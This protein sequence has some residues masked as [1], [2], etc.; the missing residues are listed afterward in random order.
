[1][2]AIAALNGGTVAPSSKAEASSGPSKSY[3]PFNRPAYE[4]IASQAGATAPVTP[5]TVVVSKDETG[6]ALP[7]GMMGLSFESDIMTD[8]RLDPGNS[9]LVA[10]LKN[11]TKPVIRFGGQAADRRFFWT[12]ASE[13]LP[14]W[15][16]VPAF[17][18]DT[19]Q[20]V[21]VTPA[22]LE[23]IN[24]TVVAAD[25]KVL[26]TADL[27][28]FDPD[29]AADFAK[30]ASA[31]FGERLLGI[32][33]GNE[34]NG[35]YVKGNPYLTLRPE[36]WSP[37]KFMDEFKAYESA[38]SKTA[39][40]VK[41]IGPETYSLNWLKP[42]A[43][44]QTPSL[45]ALSYHNYPL[46]TCLPN[47][48]F[49]PTIARVTSRA[50]MDKVK[51]VVANIAKVAKD[52]G[53]PVWLTESG[54]SSCPGSNET[55]RKHVAAMWIV[56]YALTVAQTGVTQLD[57][58]GALDTCKGG[59][60]ASPICDTGAYKRPTGVMTEQ[61]I[62]HGM[63]LVSALA[64]GMFHNVDQDGS[65]NVYS[66]AIGHKD[67]SMS[68][69]V[70]NQNDPKLSAQAPVAIQLPEAAATATMSQMTGPAFD[71]EAQTQIDSRED[72]GVPES[73]RAMIPG[74][75][76]GQQKVSLPLTSGTVT[77]LTFTF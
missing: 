74:F 44:Q 15:K 37:S 6:T 9:T 53:L 32:A 36:D 50:H 77:V 60:P 12:S 62:Y 13:G 18:G 46:S 61:A 7:D 57:V 63:M 25:A 48:E 73:Q 29:R 51:T 26:L 8:P 34:P 11:L 20:I 4:Q 54:I 24:R 64:P 41:I 28:H 58:H 27:G 45:G 55:T 30:N 2:V 40:N 19:R 35:Y 72:A 10:E 69:V 21:K 67:G 68:V 49:F 16:L 65:E 71:A 47:E 66:Y 56:N 31:I 5:T 76:P 59:P 33:I 70:V 43:A 3:A 22:D 52:S 1:M 75:V 23:R 42:F 38:I 14:D 39:P 17:Q